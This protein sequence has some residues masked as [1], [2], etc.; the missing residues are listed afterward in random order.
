MISRCARTRSSRTRSSS[1]C[2]GATDEGSH[3]NLATAWAN[4]Q[5]T[6]LAVDALQPAL[7]QADPQLTRSATSGLERLGGLLAAHR[8]AN[9]GWTPLDALTTAQRQRINGATS[10]L[11]ETLELIPDQLQ[12]A[13][14][15]GDVD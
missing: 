12:P 3:T 6:G 10:S 13:P 5:G 7:S 11:L 14:S 8:T 1:S 15:G 2:T 9:G 4:V